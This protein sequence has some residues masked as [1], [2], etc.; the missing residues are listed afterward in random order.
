MS[1]FLSIVGLGPGQRDLITPQALEAIANANVVIGYAGYF[2]WIEDLVACKECVRLPLGEEAERARIALV[3]AREKKQVCVI[4]SGDAGVY[5]M[6][7]IVLELLAR[8]PDEAAP[9]VVVVPGV[10]AITACAALLGAPLGHDFAVISL[11]D[12]LTPWERI[13]RRVQAA[14]EADFILAILNPQS[15]RR[16]WQLPKTREILLR[17]RAPE[18]PV[19]SVRNAYRPGQEIRLATL[20]TMLD[21]PVDMFTTIIV[22]NSQTR[23]FRGRLVTPR[24]YSV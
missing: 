21:L 20:A 15:R 12:L 23:A 18:T 24:G 2:E 5:G 9:E 16:D 11:S 1:G 17:H 14:A 6:A 19:G 4:S 8:E 10:S 3:H 7:S 13:E 22:G